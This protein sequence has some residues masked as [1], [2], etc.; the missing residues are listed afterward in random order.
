VEADHHVAF[1]REEDGAREFGSTNASDEISYSVV[2]ARARV[3]LEESPSLLE[4]SGD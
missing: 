4:E 1:G 2:S 3:A